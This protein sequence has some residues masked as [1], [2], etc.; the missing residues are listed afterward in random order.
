MGERATDVEPIDYSRGSMEINE[1]RATFDIFIGLVK[2][3]SLFTAAL[4]LFLS[5]WF[6][7]EAGFFT[8]FVTAAVLVVAGLWVLKKKNASDRPH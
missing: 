5:V 3:G 6:G 4:L 1:Q 8:A 2:W 7:T